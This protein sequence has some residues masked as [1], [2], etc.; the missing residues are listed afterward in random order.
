MNLL[1]SIL[2]GQVRHLLTLG[3]GALI[4]AGAL[5]KADSDKAVEIAT[6]IALWLLGAGLSALNKG[7]LHGKLDALLGTT[8]S[9]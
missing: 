8:T 5:Q 1:K 4:S 3:A 6:G 7:V 9:K 2:G